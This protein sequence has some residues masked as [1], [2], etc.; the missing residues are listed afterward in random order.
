MS[1]NQK[2]KRALLSGRV[3]EV[4]NGPVDNFGQGHDVMALSGNR[5]MIA[6][7]MVRVRVIYVA[8]SNNGLHP[9]N[10]AAKLCGGC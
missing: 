7:V 10:M 4:E 6:G 3:W 1:G 5:V 8:V 9:M 2:Q